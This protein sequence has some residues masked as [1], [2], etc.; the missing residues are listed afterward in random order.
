[1]DTT[2]KNAV[3]AA[4]AVSDGTRPRTKSPGKIRDSNG[5]VANTRIT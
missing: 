1:M 5:S 4:S 2:T 3:L